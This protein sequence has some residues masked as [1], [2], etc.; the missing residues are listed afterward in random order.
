MTIIATDSLTS[1]DLSAKLKELTGEDYFYFYDLC[2][3]NR[4]KRQH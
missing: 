1:P 3:P 4:R 2:G